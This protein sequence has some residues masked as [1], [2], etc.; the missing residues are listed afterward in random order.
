MATQTTL[1]VGTSAE[2]TALETIVLAA[3]R[4]AAKL[5]DTAVIKALYLLE[6]GREGIF[7]WTSG[8][9]SSLITVDVQEGVYLKANG[10]A[11]SVGAW[12]RQ[13]DGLDLNVTWFGA[14]V[15]KVDNTT[16]FI[17]AANLFGFCSIY[18]PRGTFNFTATI[19]S[20]AGFT[21]W[22]GEGRDQ[23]IL[24]WNAD[25]DGFSF[26]AVS[27]SGSTVIEDMSLFTTVGAPTRA[28]IRGVF[29]PAMLKGLTVSRCTFRGETPFPDYWGTGI[30]THNANSPVFSDLD[31]FGRSSTVSA[32]WALTNAAIECT[33]DTGVSLYMFD[34]IHT[35][36]YHV[37][38]KFSASTTPCIEGVFVRN[39]NLVFGNYGIHANFS[40][41]P[42]TARTLHY[43][44]QSSHVEATI[45]ALYFNKVHTVTVKDILILA[46][47]W[48]NLAG[49]MVQFVNCDKIDTDNIRIV[50]RPVHTT[51]RGIVL[52]GC[53]DASIKNTTGDSPAGRSLVRF[54]G[55]ASGLVEDGKT[56]QEGAGIAFEDVSSTPTANRG[57]R[58]TAPNG[59]RWNGDILE[60]WGVFTGTTDVNGDIVVPYPRFFPNACYSVVAI[61]SST[62]NTVTG[63]EAVSTRSPGIGD[64][65]VRCLG[66]ANASR[67]IRWEA[68]GK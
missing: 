40:A 57:G 23:T 32:D 13:R 54:E 2:I 17:A 41:I 38:L 30:K 63:S 20:N 45:Q 3:D 51:L 62:S 19:T 50:K 22:Y 18:I 48:Q 34:N 58:L 10:V 59:W 39:C 28:A 68:K 14:S 53:T 43:D 15:D 42:G 29:I 56:R 5:L 27:P 1:R 25:C 52:N 9:F 65:V 60:Q 7:K 8:N 24:Q 47:P 4:A 26:G 64:V 49:D 16:A 36:N 46:A 55:A 61:N 37:G 35:L 31:F 6:P 12:V 33:A 67:T 11:S 66:A 44:I 21:H